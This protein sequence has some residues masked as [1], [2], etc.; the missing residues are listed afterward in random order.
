MAVTLHGRMGLCKCA[1]L[2]VLEGG[3]GR[4]WNSMMEGG[5]EAKD[6]L[7]CMSLKCLSELR[8]HHPL[9]HVDKHSSEG[10]LT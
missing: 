9:K 4:G 5:N 7:I 6:A 3:G 10:H 1:K 8:F 2:K